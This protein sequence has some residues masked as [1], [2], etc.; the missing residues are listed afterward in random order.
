MRKCKLLLLVGI[1][2][3]A[4]I[5]FAQTLAPDLPSKPGGGYHVVTRP[6]NAERIFH[7][8]G[9]QYK[10]LLT[11][12]EAKSGRAWEPSLPLPITLDQAEEIARKELSKL[13]SDEVRWQF[14]EFSISRLR[15]IDGLIWYFA[16][17]LKPI[18]A[19]GEVTSD[20]FTVLLDSSG[21]P[22]RIGGFPW[23]P[24]KKW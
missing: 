21:K 6:E 5:L 10:S 22:G 12:Q 20:S 7:L 18:P 23:H 17:T 16:M 24:E 8:Q 3:C 19:V 4:A 1:T 14:T 9:K 2:F 11:W 15:G 13:V